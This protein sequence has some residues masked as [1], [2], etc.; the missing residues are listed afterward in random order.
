MY[1]ALECK[2]NNG[3]EIQNLAVIASGIVLHLKLVKSANEEKVIAA[4]AT[5]DAIAAATTADNYIT[6]ANKAGKRTQVLLELT[7][8]YHHSGRLV[9]A[10]SY[11]AFRGG[12]VGNEGEGP[13]HHWQCE[14]VQQV[15]SHG[16]HWEYNPPTTRITS[17]PRIN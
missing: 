4:S 16:I 14:A 7:E 12:G 15:V 11:F 9:T 13:Y 10:I 8:P 6:A 17:G 5:A 3:G 1:L 2:P